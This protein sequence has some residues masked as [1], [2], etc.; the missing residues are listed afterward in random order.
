MAELVSGI[1]VAENG[2][3]TNTRR[4]LATDD[5]GRLRTRVE[6]LADLWQFDAIASTQSL[7]DDPEGGDL[8]P[9]GPAQVI[10]FIDGGT[11][12]L[13]LL[14]GRTVPLTDLAAGA[15]Y[16]GR[17]TAINASSGKVRV[18]W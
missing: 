14:N 4:E 3:V 2:T 12:T 9:P 1:E 7:L 11:A 16:E 8:D 10:E 18:G 13:V 5:K 17:F 15:V 6:P